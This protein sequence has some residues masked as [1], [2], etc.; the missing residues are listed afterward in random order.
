M[1]EFPPI[2]LEEIPLKNSIL[3]ARNLV[4]LIP[5]PSEDRQWFEI[6]Y[7]QWALSVF[8]KTTDGLI[9]EITEQLPM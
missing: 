6:E 8:S 2:L 7:D 4:P 3:K 1:I 9:P 5:V